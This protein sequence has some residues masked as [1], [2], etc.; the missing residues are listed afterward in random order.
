MS[1]DVQVDIPDPFDR[2]AFFQI[3]VDHAQAL[4]NDGVVF[5]A[6]TGKSSVL[7]AGLPDISELVLALGSAGAFAALAQVLKTYFSKRPAG[8][9]TIRRREGTRSVT[10][11]ADRC[12]VASVAEAIS[13]VLR[14]TGDGKK[15]D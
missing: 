2:R 1:M 9:I 7:G 10:I 6:R 15:T 13:G 14:G 8:T 4:Q 12:D 5:N 11:R 3:L